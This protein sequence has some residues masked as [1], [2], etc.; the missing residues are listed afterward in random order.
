VAIPGASKTEHALQ[1]V[2]AMNLK[3]TQDEVTKLDELS[4]TI[5]L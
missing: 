4:R 2:G 1:N 5:A 3:L